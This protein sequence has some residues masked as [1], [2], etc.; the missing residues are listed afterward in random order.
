MVTRKAK[1]STSILLRTPQV[2][3][4]LS[5]GSLLLDLAISC[6]KSAFGGIPTK[7]IVE[8]S[9]S[10]AAGKSYINGEIC[11]DALR[12]G[13]DVY[14]DDIERR[15]DLSRLGT[16]GI[17]L[18]N[19]KFH[20]LEPGSSSVEKCFG[21]MFSAMDKVEPGGKLLYIVDPI[22]ALYSDV[23]LV[24]SDKMGQAKS[25]ALQKNMR[26]LK[27][28][29]SGHDNTISVVFSNQLIDAVGSPVPMKIVP[30]GNAMKHW[31]SVRVAFKSPGKIPVKVSTF[32]KSVDLV[33]G[34][35]LTAM[36]TK[37]SED[38]A[39]RK[40][41]F[42]IRY[43]HGIDNIHDCTSWLKACTIDLDLSPEQFAATATK[44][45]E[46]DEAGG[47][48]KKQSVWFAFLDHKPVF[49][50]SRFVAYVEE[51]DLEEQLF[52]LTA[53]RY[54][55]IHKTVERKPKVRW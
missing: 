36:V 2:T 51:N 29:V 38:D 34:I 24:R 11:G 4:Y 40:V 30:G 27:D 8:T 15:W 9:G 12:K 1:S 17:E 20:Y 45:S 53:N 5:T 33:G 47:K 31:P 54:K 42:T 3:E 23:E 48:S 41:D 37:N 44:S 25:K 10:G 13:F 52:S 7:R 16:F 18:D 43:G 19:P 50:L 39:F 32:G 26:Y 46:G 55:E 21:T 35:K 6:N 28:R 22:A 49:R 14:V